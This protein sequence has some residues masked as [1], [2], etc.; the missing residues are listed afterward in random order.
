[1]SGTSFYL[2]LMLSIVGGPLFFV[3]L[4]SLAREDANDA[5]K[6]ERGLQDRRAALKRALEHYAKTYRLAPVA[7]ANRLNSEFFAEGAARGVQLALGWQKGVS[8]L[9]APG[10]C[11]CIEVTCVATT[12]LGNI[13]ICRRASLIHNARLASSRITADDSDIDKH[14]VLFA[15]GD[16]NKRESAIALS[17]GPFRNK[18]APTLPQWLTPDLASRL[19]ELP[20]AELTV[21]G[22][23]V[24]LRL[25]ATPEEARRGA[26]Q[27]PPDITPDE[28]DLAI[29]R[30]LDIAAPAQNPP[31]SA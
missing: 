10:P 15:F 16:R 18:D 31:N 12:D 30:V 1:M 14:L 23:Q 22:Y 5:K 9:T 4:A 25:G 17:S 20:M 26:T 13:A 3:W 24:A 11:S 29:Q 28:I 7:L 2:L 21:N 27:R 19:A 6:R 8:V